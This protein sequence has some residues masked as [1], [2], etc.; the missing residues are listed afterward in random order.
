MIR[1]KNLDQAHEQ[2]TKLFDTENNDGVELLGRLDVLI[3]GLREHW[4]GEDG[5]KHINRLID[6]HEKLQT[7]LTAT[8]ES[9]RD[10]MISVVNLQ[11]VRR[12][13][14]GGG[15]V[16]QV[17]S[18]VSDFQKSIA[19]VETTAEYYIDPTITN[20]YKV[21]EEVE[22]KMKA[23]DSTFK[24][25]RNELMENWTDGSNRAQVQANFDEIETLG[26]EAEKVLAEVKQEL[27]TS[28]Q[29]AQQVM[30]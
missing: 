23:F 11:E 12:S 30:E 4:I 26:A 22:E 18:S 14:G 5:T 21:L 28:I 1:V 24:S 19:R 3:A 13:N 8:L 9:T 2:T 6:I 17:R 25:Q 27:N 7:F 15:Q 29:N 20:D 10:A 16:G